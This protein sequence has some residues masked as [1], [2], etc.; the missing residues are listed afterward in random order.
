MSQVYV[1][2]IVKT[3]LKNSLI[4][5]EKVTEN[6]KNKSISSKLSGLPTKTFVAT[7][8]L[9]NSPEL[10]ALLHP[11]LLRAGQPKAK[12]ATKAFLACRAQ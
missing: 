11:V 2:K 12:K 6:H 1:E 7:R 5:F 3:R 4:N 10:V 8:Q 9:Q